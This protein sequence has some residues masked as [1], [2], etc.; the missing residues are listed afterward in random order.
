LLHYTEMKTLKN[1]LR[2]FGLA[3]LILM[4]LSGIG[5]IGA[6]F[7]T[8]ERY[9]DREIKIEMVDKKAHEKETVGDQVQVKD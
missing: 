3:I 7:N 9:R 4:A 2:A 1:I 8:R 6:I 5:F